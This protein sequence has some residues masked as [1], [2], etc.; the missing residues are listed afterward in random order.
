[1]RHVANMLSLSLLVAATAC[2]GGDSKGPLDEVDSIV[3]IQRQARTE[4]LGD[5]FQYQSYVA[6]AKLMSIDESSVRNIPGFV[7]V[8]SKGN[9]V[10]V[11]CERE[12]QAIRAARTPH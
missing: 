3:F 11:V 2:G 4:G 1:M 7:K 10:A 5:I 12:E 9:Y 8:V 6:G